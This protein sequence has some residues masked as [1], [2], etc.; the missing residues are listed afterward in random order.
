MWQLDEEHYFAKNMAIKND[1]CVCGCVHVRLC[2]CLCLCV[3][4]C[5]HV[6]LY[7][8]VCLFV[9]LC[10]KE[11]KEL[12]EGLKEIERGKEIRNACQS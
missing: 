3:C 11:K 8:C 1:V 6:R 7:V 10:L 4:V 9:C 12:A 5:V 2:V